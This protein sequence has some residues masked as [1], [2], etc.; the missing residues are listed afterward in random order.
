MKRQSKK[1]HEDESRGMKHRKEARAGR[2]YNRS[3]K[4]R[5]RESEGMKEHWAKVHH[6]MKELKKWMR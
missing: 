2:D 1:D 4:H 6:H 3:K 5:E